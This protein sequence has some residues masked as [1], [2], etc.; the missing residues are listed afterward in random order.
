MAGDAA[1][2]AA[3]KVRPS[4]EKLNEMDRPADDNTWHDK[5]DFS[6]ENLKQQASG[7]YGGNLK[8]DARDVAN[9][10][11]N[12]SGANQGNDY[13]SPQLQDPRQVDKTEIGRAHV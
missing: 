12:A 9:S 1:S 4:D 8:Q 6:K 5:P 11:A 13:T 7:V 10:G 3:Q 2:N